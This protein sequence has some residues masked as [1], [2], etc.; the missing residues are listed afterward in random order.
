VTE[1]TTSTSAVEGPEKVLVAVG[2]GNDVVTICSDNRYLQDVVYA[3]K[4]IMRPN[5]RIRGVLC[6]HLEK[7][8]CDRRLEASRRQHQRFLLD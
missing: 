5:G 4:I 3:C 7:A 1:L 6:V 2:V 8:R